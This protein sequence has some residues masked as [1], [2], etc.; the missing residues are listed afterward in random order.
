MIKK[1]KTAETSRIW[2][3]MIGV[4]VL[5]SISCER[6]EDAE[7]PGNKVIGIE[8]SN[9]HKVFDVVEDMPAPPGG[10]EEWSGYLQETLRY[11]SEAREKG[12]EGTVYLSFVVDE[13]G[14]IRDAEVL[15]G[16]GSGCDEE[17]LQVIKNS[18]PWEA[19]MQ[20]DQ[21]VKVKMRIPIRFA[22]GKKDAEM[23]GQTENFLKEFA[24]NPGQEVFDM[25][26]NMPTPQG[27]LEAWNLY[28]GNHLTYPSEAR[29]KGIKGTVYVAFVVD[30]DGSI[31]DTEILRGIG[32]GCDEEA[33]QVI[34]NSPRWKPGL[35]NGK[36]VNVR[37]R[38]PVRFALDQ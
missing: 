33:L 15:R 24:K 28:L 32:G 14:S 38:M 9:Q 17:A 22:L 29:E 36:K 16:I 3:V 11:P 31:R 13:D 30:A 7:L 37:I 12:I 35:Q 4:T 1:L 20:K 34:K 6:Q 18:P 23:I 25:V 19:G 27:G 21:K 5:A 26:E 2:V 10:M 8:E